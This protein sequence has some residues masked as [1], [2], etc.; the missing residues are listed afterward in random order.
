MAY[1][2]EDKIDVYAQAVRGLLELEPDPER[3]IKYLDFIDIYAHLDDDERRIYQQRH[4]PETTIM[5]Q[6]AERF[7]A[8]GRLEG[9]QEGRLEAGTAILLNLLTLKFG[10]PDDAVRQRVQNADADTL[11]SWSARVLTAQCLEDVFAEAQAQ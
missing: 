4:V 7:E 8:K 1:A 6:F 10:V 9:R 11:L 2:P 3:Q 5:S